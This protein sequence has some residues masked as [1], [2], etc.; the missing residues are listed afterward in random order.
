MS[1]S[2]SGANP[3]Q[4]PRNAIV[5]LLDSL[6]RHMLGCYGGREFDT[7]N[8]DAFATRS[9]RFDRHVTGS[10]PCM[11]ARHDILTGALDFLWRPWGSIE[12]WEEPITFPL[13]L[14]G[15]TSMLVS[16]HPHLFETGGE[17]YH[18]NF[19]AWEYLRGHECD[20]WK[21][22]AD[23]SWIG[24]PALPARA[25]PVPHAYDTSRTHFREELD[26]PGPKTMQHASDWLEENAGHHDRFLLFI[27]EFDP[28]EPFDT[29]APW[30][31]RY[32]E[33]WSEEQLIWPPYAVGAVENGVITEREARHIRANYGSKLS[34]IDHWLG[35]LLDVV[36]EKGLYEDTAVIICTDHG[37][38]LGEKDIFGKPKVIQYE[39]LGHTPLLIS[40]PGRGA[41]ESRALTTNVDLHATLADIFEIEPRHRTHGESLVPLLT[42]AATSIREWAIGGV[43]GQWVQI[44]DGERKYARA[45]EGNGF[46]LSMWSNRW[47]TMPVPAFPQ[48][49]LPMPDRRAK[50]DYMPGSD[51]PVIRQPFAPGDPLPMWGHEPL[52]GEHH[53]YR[54]LDDPEENENRANGGEARRMIEMLREALTA[55]EAPTDQFERLGLG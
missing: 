52:I 9:V 6:N 7:P 36:E 26:F 27:D 2:D 31:N 14:K 22:R 16:D 18:T 48:I 41:G 13:R 40:W 53:L 25:G 21:T 4:M 15:V 28:H 39:A 51:V 43:W 10:L 19:S 34:M 17:N 47:S 32:D 55:V 49:R 30:V 45:A 24:T 50:I 20:P 8:L 23:P 33:D 37:H 3:V 38:Y 1:D 46:P 35:R 5:V 54:Y 29:P 42:G 11:P 12:L 44:N